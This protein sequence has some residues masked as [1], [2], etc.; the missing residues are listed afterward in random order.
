MGI[1]GEEALVERYLGPLT[2]RQQ[3]EDHLRQTADGADHIS[4]T[5]SIALEVRSSE[6]QYATWPLWHHHRPGET[7]YPAE[8][9][10][11]HLFIIFPMCPADCW[12]PSI[13]NKTSEQNSPA[14]PSSQLAGNKRCV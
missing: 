12:V 8:T 1:Q 14:Q 9:M 6:S 3:W 11:T 4:L 2:S 7:R 13:Q 5:N 10:A